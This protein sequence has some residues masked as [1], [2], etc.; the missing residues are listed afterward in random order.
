MRKFIKV[1]FILPII[2]SA[3]NSDD[4]DAQSVG[5]DDMREVEFHLLLKNGGNCTRSILNESVIETMMTDV[6]VAVYYPGGKVIDVRYS[7]TE[8]GKVKAMVPSQ[9]KVNVYVLV[10][11]GD[12]S[13]SFPVEETEV[14]DIAYSFDD[15]EEIAESGL[16]MAGMLKSYV[17]SSGMDDVE[18]ERLF[19]KVEVTV[20]HSEIDRHFGSENMNFENRSLFIRQANRNLMPFGKSRANMPEHILEVADYNDQMNAGTLDSGLSK[21]FVSD[22]TLVFYVPENL[23]GDLLPD[24]SDHWAKVPD[25]IS[26]SDVSGLCTYVEVTGYQEGVHGY[27]GSLIYRFYIG[28]DA[29]SNFDI[30]R[31]KVY[32]VSFFPTR[33][34]EKVEDSWKVEKGEDWTDERTL[35]FDDEAFVG[36]MGDVIPVY[37]YYSTEGEGSGVSTLDTYM[38][39]WELELD[40]EALAEAGLTLS[41]VSKFPVLNPET[42]RYCYCASFATTEET[43]TGKSIAVQARTIDGD[44]VSK[45]Y[46]AVRECS[47]LTLVT[48]Y[49]PAFVAQESSFEMK[50]LIDRDFPL[51]ISIEQENEVIKI[52]YDSEDSA[53]EFIVQAHRTGEA[54]V[55]VSSVDGSMSAVL[56]FKISA[57]KMVVDNVRVELTVDGNK[58]VCPYTYTNDYGIVLTNFNQSLFKQYLMP[59]IGEGFSSYI[60]YDCD[61]ENMYFY[62]TRLYDND[63]QISYDET[64]SAIVSASDC[65]DVESRTILVNVEDPFESFVLMEMSSIHDYSLLDSENVDPAVRDYFSERIETFDDFSVIAPDMNLMTDCF[66][67]ELVPQED[68]GFTYPNQ[69]LSLKY[70]DNDFFITG[71]GF[72]VIQSRS[73]DVLHSAGPHNIDVIVKNRYSGETISRLWGTIDVCVHTVVGAKADISFRPCNWKS[74]SNAEKSFAQVYNETLGTQYPEDS[75]NFIYYM[76]VSSEFLTDVSRVKVFRELCELAGSGSEEYD[77]SS[78][79]VP[80]VQDGYYYRIQGS[81]H[82]VIYSDDDDRIL[83]CGEEAGVRSGIGTVLYRVLLQNTYEFEL[84]E[85][86]AESLLLNSYSGSICDPRINYYE[87]GSKIPVSFF[88]DFTFVPSEYLDCV[89]DYGKGHHIIHFLQTILP[90]TNGWMNLL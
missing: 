34:G 85:A 45:A 75:G 48:D 3:C 42:G 68:E 47:T 84:A 73:P 63:V 64:L 60:S 71:K 56:P 28:D 10:N 13:S 25:N 18:V 66:W 82:S 67:G 4:Y 2:L 5:N 32:R 59:V 41:G 7:K 14:K 38:K 58:S 88:D 69:A 57:P 22:T 54:E 23:Q 87:A 26:Q 77:A 6:T 46:I 19:A 27:S 31:N 20:D 83:Y 53:E 89:D 17:V 62:V 29:T 61:I 37:I 81:Y 90:D 35:F 40:E 52:F 15:Y 16:P 9:E 70:E 74:Y 55:R 11:M 50:G 78:I 65:E 44:I 21:G 8:S 72:A 80:T 12:M 30:E 79:A 43:V 39:H 49:K 76:D 51:E 86:H 24:N 33:D 36:V 1:L